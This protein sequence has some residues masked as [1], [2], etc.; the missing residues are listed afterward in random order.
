MKGSQKQGCTNALKH[1]HVASYNWNI[2][3]PAKN[4]FVTR[5]SDPSCSNPDYL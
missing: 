4:H 1:K 3:E 5:L 2:I